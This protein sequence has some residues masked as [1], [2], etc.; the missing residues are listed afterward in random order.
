MKVTKLR[1]LGAR[2][3]EAHAC[4]TF[5]DAEYNRQ[6]AKDFWGRW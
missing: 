2:L 5:C 1:L 4:H 3:L 6:I